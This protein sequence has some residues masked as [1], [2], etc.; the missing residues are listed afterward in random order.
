MISFE[1]TEDQTLM[2]DSVAQF[3]R[4]TLQPRVRELEKLRAVPE[5]VRKVAHE[6]GLGLVAVPEAC[7]GQG[8]GLCTSVLLEEELGAADAAAPFGL[9]GPHAFAAAIVELGT[10][11]QARAELAPFAAADAHGRFGAVAWSEAAPNKER[12]GFSTIAK[13][14]GDGFE[15]DGKKSFVVNAGLAD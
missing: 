1:P 15:I 8:L 11:E 4:S 12:A 2:R 13:S 14:I 6:M 9:P 5:E 7:G 10:E 3:A